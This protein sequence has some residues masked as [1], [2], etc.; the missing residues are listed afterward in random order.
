MTWAA[1]PY[2]AAC[3]LLVAAGGAK[4]GRPDPTR[5]ALRDG[6]R[7]TLPTGAVRLAG[8]V[9]A[10][11]GATAVLTGRSA[12]AFAVTATYLAFAAF[13]IA[14]AR[15]PHPTNCGCFGAAGDGVPTGPVHVMVN[16]AAAAS[17]L[18]VATQGGLPAQRIAVTLLAGGLA[19]AT[20]LLLVPLPRLRAAVHQGRTS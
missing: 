3:L 13:T 17:A 6:L 9:E 2:L 19:Y 12:T 8:G 18:V 16:L 14:S 4:I 10:T 5:R 20:Y 1:G 15:S 7:L 11:L